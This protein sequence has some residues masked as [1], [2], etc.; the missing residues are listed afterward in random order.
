MR[1]HGAQVD[2]NL[3][4]AGLWRVEFDNFGGDG[5]RLIIDDSLVLGGDCGSSHGAVV[6]SW[7]SGLWA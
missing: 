2:Q 3:A 4:G 7:S 6:A 5:A 1:G